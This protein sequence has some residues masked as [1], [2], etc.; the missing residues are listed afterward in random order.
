MQLLVL[1]T[2]RNGKGVE[3]EVEEVEE[4]EEEEKEEKEEE[5]LE[6]EGEAAIVYT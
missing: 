3:K 5:E 4:E 6:R 1:Q 2:R